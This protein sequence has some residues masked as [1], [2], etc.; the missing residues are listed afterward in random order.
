MVKESMDLLELLRKSGV[1]GDVDFL[2]E[3]LRV[4]MDAIMDAE[5]STRIG[6]EHGERSPDRLLTATV[7]A[8]ARGIP[9][10]ARWSFAY[11]SSGKG[12]TFRVCLSRGVEARRRCWR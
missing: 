5:V 3:A 8:P 10:S 2:R 12:A 7:T 1:D 9:G 6:A 11:R 4:L